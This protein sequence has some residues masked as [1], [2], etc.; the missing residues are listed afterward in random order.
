MFQNDL[1]YSIKNCDFSMYAVNHQ[2]CAS[3]QLIEK[4][5]TLLNNEAKIVSDWYKN[6]FLLAKKDKFQTMFLVL[7]AKNTEEAQIVIDNEENECT[8][9]L[10]LLGVLI[11]TKLNLGAHNQQV[12]QKANCKIGA[13]SRMKNL[14]PKKT[15]LHL[16]KAVNYCSLVWLFLRVSDQRKLEKI[17][18]TELRAVFKDCV[19]TYE[20]LLKKV[21]LPTLH[22]RRWQDL[23]VLMFNIKNGPSPISTSLNYESKQWKLMENILTDI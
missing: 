16:F 19:S 21:G 8:S 9:S 17:Q 5:A 13:L 2:I 10:T 7:K 22:N 15:K 3:H 23:M 18:E 4:V 6:N 1:S 20:N 14:I 12:C 11:D